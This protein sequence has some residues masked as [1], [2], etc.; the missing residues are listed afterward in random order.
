M[1]TTEQGS[2]VAHEA[3]IGMV[4][5]GQL[6]RMTALAAAP[7]GYQVHVYHDSP[8]SPTAQVCARETV[9]PFDDAA[10]LEAF[11]KACD[12]VTFEWENVP[13][14]TLRIIGRHA[15]V[16]PSIALLEIAQDRAR[17]KQFAAQLGL[18]T[19]PWREVCSLPEL[20]QAVE[21]LGTPCILKTARL[22]Y[23]GKGQFKINDAKQASEAWQAVGEVRCVLEGVVDFRAELSVIVARS[24]SGQIAVYDPVENR[25]VDQILD[26]THAPAA[27]EPSIL[28]DAVSLAMAMAEGLGLEGVLGIELFL[29][30]QGQLLVNEIAPRPHNSGHWTLD[31]CH[32]SQFEQF[33][34]AICDLPLGSPRR[35]SDAVMQNLLGPVE[36]RR[37]EALADPAVKVHVYGKSEQ[38]PGR[39]TGHLT[40]LLPRSAVE[41]ALLK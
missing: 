39:K 38:R 3:T 6:G 29:T 33:V 20:E 14:E 28:S 41:A 35:H 15:V 32:T 11:A 19:A 1:S 12:V 26:S 22:G 17:E 8:G 18:G 9:A 37:S 27:V 36:P 16:R 2:P 30:G 21:E 5:G 40:R 31:A 7:L 4:A 13:V 34:R 24:P 25:H 10:A 23:D